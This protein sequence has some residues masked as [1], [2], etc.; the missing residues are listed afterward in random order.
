[1][2]VP[3]ILLSHIV[4]LGSPRL[5][6]DG[7]RLAFVR[8]HVNLKTDRRDPELVLLDIRTRA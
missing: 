7:A 3:L 2:L 6:P 1:M 4:G 8:S 5:S